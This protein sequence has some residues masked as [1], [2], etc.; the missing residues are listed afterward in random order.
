VEVQQSWKSIVSQ[1]L[2]DD[3][4][5]EQGGG[6]KRTVRRQAPGRGTDRPQAEVPDGDTD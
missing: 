6:E 4:D 1:F 3:V 5:E 2:A